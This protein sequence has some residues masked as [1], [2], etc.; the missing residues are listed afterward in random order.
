MI[1]NLFFFLILFGS[2][3]CTCTNWTD[4]NLQANVILQHHFGL[5]LHFFFRSAMV[6]WGFGLF[7]LSRLGFSCIQIFWFFFFSPLENHLFMLFIYLQP[8]FSMISPIQN[9]FLISFFS[10]AA[11]AVSQN[12]WPSWHWT[13]DK[14]WAKM[15]NTTETLAHLFP[16]HLHFLMFCTVTPHPSPT[17]HFVNELHILSVE[18]ERNIMGNCTH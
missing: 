10:Q 2:C 11:L 4:E 8:F 3:L 9:K 16:Y 12:C 17:K 1:Q 5:L 14:Y 6:F 13:Q 15:Q 18:Q 7:L